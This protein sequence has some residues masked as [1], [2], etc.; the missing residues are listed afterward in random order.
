MHQQKPALRAARPYRIPEETPALPTIYGQDG[1]GDK[2]IIPLRPRTPL[3]AG[4]KN[5]P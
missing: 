2:S 3:K 1:V 4:Q 5:V